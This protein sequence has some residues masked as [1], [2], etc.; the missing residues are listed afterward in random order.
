MLEMTTR[1]SSSWQF[2]V[3]ILAFY[4]DKPRLFTNNFLL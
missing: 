3:K 1:R 2:L 4:T